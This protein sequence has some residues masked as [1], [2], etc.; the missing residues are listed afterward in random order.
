MEKIVKHKLFLTAAG[1]CLSLAILFICLS[2]GGCGKR[3]FKDIDGV[4]ILSAKVELMPPDVELEIEDREKLAELLRSV[5][6]Y[7][8]DDSY[9]D[10]AGQAAVFTLSMRDGTKVEITEYTPFA[11]IDGVGYR[12]KYE[13]CQALNSYANALLSQSGE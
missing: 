12:A 11:I 9:K 13:P 8:Q 7:R 3:P 5:V 6:I 2:P 1:I 10:Y 4:D